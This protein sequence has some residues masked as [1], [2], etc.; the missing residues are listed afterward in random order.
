MKFMENKYTLYAFLGHYISGDSLS[1]IKNK[2]SIETGQPHE[3]LDI[4]KTN[5]DTAEP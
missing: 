2:N 4:C 1:T 5:Y 3:Y